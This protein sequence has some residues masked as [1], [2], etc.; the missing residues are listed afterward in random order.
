MNKFTYRRVVSRHKQ[1][2]KVTQ[3][4]PQPPHECEF[5]TSSSKVQSQ[6]TP[7]VTWPGSSPLSQKNPN[8]LLQVL[9]DPQEQKLR[10]FPDFQNHLAQ[11]NFSCLHLHVPFELQWEYDAETTHR[12]V[13]QTPHLTMVYTC[14]HQPVV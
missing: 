12:E 3:R 2:H 13:P 14:H 11:A 4:I 7:V 6:E 8:Y 1:H 5:I 10:V 9:A